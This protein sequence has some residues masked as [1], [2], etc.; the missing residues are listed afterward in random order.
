MEIDQLVTSSQAPEEVEAADS[1]PPHEQY[2]AYESAVI[3]QE[4]QQEQQQKKENMEP[5]LTSLHLTGVDDLSTQQIKKYL[6]Y[7]IKPNYSFKTRK[8]FAYLEYRL[9][10]INDSEINIV[11]DYNLSNGN[12]KRAKKNQPNDGVDLLDEI[13]GFAKKEVPQ[14]SVERDTDDEM[15]ENLK[16]E[17]VTE[18]GSDTLQGLENESIRGAAEA[19]LLLTDFEDIRK[20]HNE[21]A[22]LSIEDQFK[23]VDQAPKLQDRKCWDL[24]LAKNGAVIKTTDA[25]RFYNLFEHVV[26]AKDSE[27]QLP[28]E[29][30]IAGPTEVEEAEVFSEDTK[31]IKLEVRYSTELDKKVENARVFSRYYLLHGEPDKIERLPSARERLTGAYPKAAGYDRDLITAAEPETQGLFGY[32][33]DREE[34]EVIEPRYREREYRGKGINGRWSSDR[35]QAPGGHDS[36]HNG[37]RISKRGPRSDR[38]RAGRGNGNGHGRDQLEGDLFPDFAQRRQQ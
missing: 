24:V 29:E 36:R 31:I 1:K 7:H 12:G 2:V 17:S 28:N 38:R 8:Q 10:W 5:I 22:A 3:E 30:A 19:L 15:K 20:E 16:E 23:A 9:D 37:S 4:Q 32:D 6:D 14:E 27:D 26:Q 11:F 18:T 21:F 35:F 25:K 13:K 34:R 33:G